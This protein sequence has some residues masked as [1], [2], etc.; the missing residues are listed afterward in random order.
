MKRI[1]KPKIERPNSAEFGI[2]VEREK[3]NE[4]MSN[5]KGA[6]S[7]LIRVWKR[8]FLEFSFIVW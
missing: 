6:G 5:K 1:K 2:W 3:T 8:D 4:N 7:K